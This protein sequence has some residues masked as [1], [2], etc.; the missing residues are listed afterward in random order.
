MQKKNPAVS[1]VET[2]RMRLQKPPSKSLILEIA[3]EAV[4][5]AFVLNALFQLM[6]SG[7]KSLRWRA[8]WAVEKVASMHPSLL[9]GKYDEIRGWVLSTDTSDSFKRL[10]LGVLYHLPKR[11][12][13]DVE[14]FNFLLDKM[15]DLQS[16][17]SVQ[18][19]SMKLASRMSCM[20]ADLHDEF[21]CIL[22]NMCL[23][24]YSAGVRAAVRNCLKEKCQGL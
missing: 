5:D 11:E 16:P 19:L 3:T 24:F 12:A 4:N 8:A 23:E 10:L 6:A 13:L 14:L 21:L 20:D 18:A 7:D 1:F 17:S 9:I 2:L 15:V 22:R